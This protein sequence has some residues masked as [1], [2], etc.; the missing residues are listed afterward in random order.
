[1][2]KVLGILI[3]LG[4]VGGS[5]FVIAL[6]WCLDEMKRKEYEERKKEDK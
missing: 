1:M 6:N 5:I 2:D 4:I 3:G